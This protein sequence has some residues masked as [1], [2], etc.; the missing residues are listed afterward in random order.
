MK[1]EISQR[2]PKHF[3]TSFHFHLL[4]SLHPTA[5]HPQIPKTPVQII[6]TVTM[7]P[8]PE[9]EKATYETATT[10]YI[11]VGDVKYAYRYFGTPSA[12]APTFL[13][14]NHFKSNMDWWDPLFVNPL[15][16]HRPILLIDNAGTG[17]S[18]GTVGASFRIWAQTVLSVVEALS[19]PTPLDLLGFSMGGFTALTLALDSPTAVRRLVIAGS[20]PSAGPDVVSADPQHIARLAA[21]H[22][23]AENGV[24]MRAT[25]FSPSPAK[26]ALADAWWERMTHARPDPAPFL[27]GDA[28][29]RQ[30]GAVTRHMGG[31]HREEAT[32]D[33]LGELTIPVLIGNGSDDV[34]VPTENS[35]VLFRRLV[36]ARPHLH[37]Y[38][39]SSHGF[40]DEFHEHFS[41]LVNGFL[42]GEE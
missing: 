9:L 24:G 25:F 35:W 32:Y 42:E 30:I 37:L 22:T 11:T 8:L 13:M 5:L 21:A 18:T 31:A 33:R 23:T 40:L 7:S 29:T 17:R 3:E 2:N 39:D 16:A 6:T 27:T 38:P 12:T 26:Q 1:A 10:K 36:N 15:A 4:I 34:L 14:L 20:G 28:V 19:I 41:G